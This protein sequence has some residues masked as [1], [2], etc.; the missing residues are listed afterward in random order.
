MEDASEIRQ[1][2]SSKKKNLILAEE[3]DSYAKIILLLTPIN[4]VQHLQ[5][6]AISLITNY[7][8]HEILK[9]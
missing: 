9:A 2:P 6:E 8:I 1:S 5:V 7:N 4:M 3:Y